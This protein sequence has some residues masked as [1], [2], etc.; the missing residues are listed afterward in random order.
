MSEESGLE[1]PSVGTPT[2]QEMIGTPVSPGIAIAPVFVFGDILDEVEVRPI[3]PSEVDR[4]L[5]RLDEAVDLVKQELK[6]DADHISDLLG[7]EHADIF[8][9]HSMILEDKAVLKTIRAKIRDDLVN[10]EAA[11]ADEMK[12]MVDVLSASDD[13]YLRDRAFDI[14]DIGKRVIERM[15]GVWAHCPLS[16][17]MVLVAREL[18]ASDTASMD[19][20]RLLGFVTELGGRE[21]H[22]A[23]LARSIGVPAIVGVAGIVDRLKTGDVVAVDGS[24]GS[25]VVHPAAETVSEYEARRELRVQERAD[26]ASVLSLPAVTRDGVA[27]TLM[28][29]AGSV[30]D[31]REAVNLGADG[32]GL[33]RTEMIFMQAANFLDED[34]QYRAYSEAAEVMDGRPVTIR[35]LDVGGDKF[36]GP[37]NPFREHNPNL[38]YR[39]TRVLLDRP[40]ILITQ[41]RAILR[42]ASHGNVRMLLPM[43]SSVEELR[44]VQLRVEQ[45]SDALSRDRLAFSDSVKIGVMIEIPSAAM[46]SERLA[47]EC[48]FLSI[49]TND[50]VQYALAVDRGSSYVSRLYRPHDPSVLAL[51]DITVQGATAAGKPVSLCGEMA[52]N[53]AYVPL[54]IGLGLREL[55]CSN[56]LLPGTKRAIRETDTIGATALARNAMN[57]GT[58]SDVGA[59]LGLG[60][61]ASAESLGS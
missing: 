44:E 34:S 13:S 8:L 38:G 42:A 2:P 57:A 7:K 4:E 30:E 60:G 37:E 5:S 22:A 41:L 50:L 3:A 54:L 26:L 24:S 25:V 51:I 12:R 28:T 32:I 27:V 18:R 48:D 52:G 61:P 1:S 17:P 15:L 36:V 21:S 55:S 43:I 10:A 40:D 11:V 39:S 58:A 49:G 20:G 59:L 16:Q 9:V 19:R 23:I 47:T 46:V 45:A 31:V 56:S 14:S 53:P 35:T 6:R 29:N 33:L